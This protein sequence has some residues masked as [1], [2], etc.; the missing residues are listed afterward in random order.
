MQEA[1]SL[2]SA[3]YFTVTELNPSEIGRN[4]LY[5]WRWRLQSHT[6]CFMCASYLTLHL[7]HLSGK[8]DLCCVWELRIQRGWSS[9]DVHLRT[10]IHLGQRERQRDT[11][12]R[13][14][15]EQ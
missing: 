10:V 9:F 1:T 3:Q 11:D 5:R 8:L 2:G 6:V 15:M 7:S 13:Y 12:L 14:R 4:D